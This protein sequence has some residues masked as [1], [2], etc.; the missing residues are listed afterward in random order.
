V[1]KQ[2]DRSLEIDAASN[3]RLVTMIQN[4]D[5]LYTDKEEEIL[6]DGRKMLDVF[7]QQKSKE[8]KMTSPTTQA[9]I[10]FKPGDKHAFGWATTTVRASSQEVLAFVWNTEAR[11]KTRP[12]DLEKA[13]DEEPNRHNKLVYVRAQAKRAQK[14][15]KQTPAS[16]RAPVG[17]RAP[18]S[19][20]ESRYSLAL[21]HRS[22]PG[23]I[24]RRHPTSCTTATSSGG[25][26]G[27]RRATR[28]SRSSPRPRR[29][30][31]V[32]PV[33]ILCVPST[34]AQ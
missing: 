6:E 13:V 29:A 20:K 26:S 3:L 4:H 10:A 31:G 28:P 33:P 5:E 8:L 27:R 30:S 14:K 12:D 15:S 18:A 9:K 23:T 22:P 19:V 1:R 25:Q 17:E 32:D 7:A 11:S 2:Y 21:A 16:E 34:R 24:G